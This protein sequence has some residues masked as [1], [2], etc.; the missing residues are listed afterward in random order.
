MKLTHKELLRRLRK[1][2]KAINEHI[3]A[4]NYGG[5]AVI[6]ALVSTQLQGL[7]VEVEVVTKDSRWGNAM[8]APA[9]V[10]GN[11]R[12]CPSAHE[13]ESEDVSF[14]HVAVRFRSKGR[15]WTWDSESMHRCGSY[16]GPERRYSAAGKFGEGLT[17]KEAQACADTKKFWN[18]DF[19]RKQIPKLRTLV[20]Y[21]LKYGL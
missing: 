6:A 18:T 10:R 14:G 7:G 9:K 20:D 15:C 1:L 2:G 5:C 4:P 11:L 12:P 16:F 19:N 8:N 17:P 13:W 3:D 21:H